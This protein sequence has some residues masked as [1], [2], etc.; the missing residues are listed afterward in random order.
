[1]LEREHGP[2]WISFAAVLL[3][4]VL[5]AE[6]FY[7]VRQNSQTF[8]ESAHLYAGYSY[9]KTHDFGINPEHP[10]LAK[11]VAALP[12][13][14]LRLAVNPPPPIYFR[15]ASAIGGRQFLY[16]HDASALLLRSRLAI[17]VFTFA[18]AF[19]VFLAG[20]EM[21]G[22]QAGLI[23]LLVLVFEPNIL[24]NGALV[25]TDMAVT[26]MLFGTVYTFYRYLKQP[27]FARLLVCSVFAGLTLSVKHSAVLMLPILPLLGLL[28]LAFVRDTGY[29]TSRRLMRRAWLTLASLGFIAAVSLTILWACYGFHY[30]ARPGNAPMT[31][32]TAAFLETLHKPME[33]SLIGFSERHHLL[34]EAYLYGMTDIAVL[35]AEGRD[36]YLFGRIYPQGR[37]FYFPSAFL[38]KSTLGFL[39]LL[40]LA[41]GARKLWGRDLRREILCLLV[42]PAVYLAIAMHSKLDLGLRHILPIY[43]FLIVLAAAGAWTFMRRSRGWA[44]AVSAL[45]VLH[46][47]SSLKSYPTYLP[48]SNEVW[49]GPS[50]TY[51]V[52]ADANVGWSSGLPTLQRYIS[53]HGITHC[54]FAYNGPADLPYFH[55]PCSR[56][57]SFFSV[58]MGM[59]QGVTP[60]AIDGPLFIST[61]NLSLSF[62]GPPDLDPYWQFKDL[63]P[64]AVLAG[65]ILVFQGTFDVPRISA[66]SHY[67][68]ANKALRTGHP[69]QA[70]P[71]AQKAEALAPEMLPP[72]E[73][74]S[75]LY[76]SA[77]QTDNAKREYQSAMQIYRTRYGEFANGTPPPV[78]P[79]PTEQAALS[80]T[81]PPAR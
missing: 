61:E 38:I 2:R 76:A 31:P 39:L 46:A 8:D 41:L 22:W 81:K 19:L 32:P 78:D 10:P 14:P 7:S 24:A 72:H 25:T 66:M 12:L 55:L 17:S 28:H 18:L 6:L 4:T 58:I 59:E 68:L 42:P 16:S 29:G 56:L 21:F 27:T 79:V 11:M 80:S 30:S 77:H 15:G 5:F 44:V 34:P 70:L 53:D 20:R 40:V 43:P 51:K 73:M 52:L 48:Y 13:L 36:T 1:M 49:G 69:E 35:T 65:D 74:L 23:A 64:D 63:K 67:A 45:L 75:T 33:A 57:P 3:F 47:A 37:W 50:Q 26:A 62:W 54:W 60:A 9:W 71:E